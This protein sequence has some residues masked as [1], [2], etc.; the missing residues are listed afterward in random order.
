MK[1]V[2]VFSDGDLIPS[3]SKNV[4]CDS[5]L[6][7]KS[8]HKGPKTFQDHVKSKFDIIH[9]DVHGA[10]AIQLL[11]GKRHFVTFI[12]EFSRYTWI[13]FVRYKSDVKTVF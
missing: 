6:Q 11:S 10:L 2:N 13:Y 8:T 1:S 4:D 7:S 9:S 12:D 5:G 3:K